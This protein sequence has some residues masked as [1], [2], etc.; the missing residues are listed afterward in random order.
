[1][2]LYINGDDLE[3][4]GY[5]GYDI[6]GTS[7]DIKRLTCYQIPYTSK[8]GHLTYAQVCISPKVA[9][10]VIVLRRFQPRWITKK[11]QRKYEI[12]LMH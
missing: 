5:I 11:L 7:D 8:V 3:I 9:Y 1:M 6:A 4:V 10:A 12:P 2:I